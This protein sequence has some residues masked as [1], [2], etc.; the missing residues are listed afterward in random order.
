MKIICSKCKRDLGEKEPLEDRRVTHGFAKNAIS[1]TS[2]RSTK[3]EY[4]PSGIAFSR[5]NH[6]VTL[7]TIGNSEGEVGR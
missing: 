7:I 4:G 2:R 1:R 6:L 5:I 3:R